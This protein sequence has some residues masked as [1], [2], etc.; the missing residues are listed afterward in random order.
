MLWGDFAP[1]VLGA[2]VGLG[3][4]AQAGRAQEMGTVLGEQKIAAGTGGFTGGL[5]AGDDFGQ[6]LA[7]A[8]D[9]DGDE[10][11]DL[12]VAAPDDDDGGSNRGAVWVLFL[13]PDGTV[14]EQAKIS[15]LQGGFAGP[16]DNVDRFGSAVAALGDR[17]GD[18]RPELAVGAELDD[19][20]GLN[21]GA[22]WI[23]SLEPDGRVGAASKISASSAG[24]T[25]VLREGDRFG[26]S[27]ASLADLDGDGLSELAVGANGDRDG[28]TGRGAVWVLFLDAQGG[29]KQHTKISSTSG[30]FAGPLRD[31]DRFGTALSSPGDLDKDGIPELA[32]G[33]DLDND[34]GTDCGAAWILFLKP[35]GSVR[36][37][38]KLS[39]LSGLGLHSSDQFGA[40]LV[41]PGDVDGD[42]T[43]DLVVGAPLDDDGG[44]KRGALWVLFLRPDGGLKGAQKISATTG[45][46]TGPLANSA[47]FGTA[48]TA[49]GDL[50]GD[51]KLDLVAGAVGDD[52]GG[53][54]C[55]AL[56]VL[57]LES[58]TPPLLVVRNGL[59]IN[60][61]LLSADAAPA[62]GG[63]WQVHVDCRGFG[64]GIVI[65]QVGAR[66]MDGP[67]LGKLGQ[68]LIDWGRPC[69]VRAVARHRGT[70]TRLYHCVPA[71]PALVG[72]GFY[73]QALVTGRY[74][75]KLT[76]ALDGEFV[77]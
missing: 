64:K 76:N 43:V 6:G 62:V 16:L 21:R 59:G 65:H 33:A 41:A 48:L 47:F 32:V 39:I 30:S 27:L 53:T 74:G 19:D 72:L 55:G 7:A 23:L 24:F 31:G 4:F 18:G 20:G 75:A 3:L 29:V 34:G 35:E 77:R 38:A 9:V 54:D 66:P 5:D 57:F 56:W 58:A 61:L 12:V 13:N 40:S 69:F 67:V 2:A 25:G 26:R 10:V 28:G 73:S 8:G 22:V 37:Q 42:D 71:N 1:M 50:D 68:I 11:V 36:T 52:T 46:L 17:D 15:S 45:G 70:D 51:R 60:P 49:L 44:Q 63:K 14:R